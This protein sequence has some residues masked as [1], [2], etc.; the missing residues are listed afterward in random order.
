VWAELLP[1][2]RLRYSRPHRR[3]IFFALNWVTNCIRNV[4]RKGR[5]LVEGEGTQEGE[6]AWRREGLSE[7]KGLGDEIG[8]SLS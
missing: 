5:K 1:P 2:K 3:R 8:Q 7:D 6:L 4:A